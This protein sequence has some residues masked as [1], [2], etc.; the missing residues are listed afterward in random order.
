MTTITKKT[1]QFL[2]ILMLFSNF[3]NA[4]E[5]TT[6][7]DFIQ[8]NHLMFNVLGGVV[9]GA[10]DIT[11]ERAI[12][13]RSTVSLGL[14]YK[15]KGLFKIS[16]LDSPTIKTND[17]GF[18]G[19]IVTPEY[20]WYFQKRTKKYTGFYVGGYYR[21]KSLADDVMGT[22]TSSNTSTTSP[23][24]LEV[25]IIT[26]TVGVQ[27]GYKLPISNN[28]YVDFLIAGPGFSAQKIKLKEN[29]PLPDEFLVDVADAL[30]DNFNAFEQ[31]IE[32]VNFEVIDIER[33]EAK[34][35]LPAFRY[36]IRIGYSF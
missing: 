36:N 8:K 30:V 3:L 9:T 13:H 1:G 11:Y 4:Q 2:L 27:L 14:G 20:K 35:G 33:A 15:G 19:L 17:F 32:N 31:L 25:D 34:F 10:W 21:F 12:S 24:D 28:F 5:L 22:Y 18:T 16:G 6:K 26:N 7:D 23:I 29:K